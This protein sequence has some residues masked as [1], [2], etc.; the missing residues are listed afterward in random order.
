MTS[1]CKKIAISLPAELVEQMERERAVRSESRSAFIRRAV[2]LL[3][4]RQSHAER[5]AEYV[6]GYR[7]HP[8]GEEEAVISQSTTQELFDEEPWE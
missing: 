5:V 2:E 3:F 7:R 1:H 4:L 6:A 8:E